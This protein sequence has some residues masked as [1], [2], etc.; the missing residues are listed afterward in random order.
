MD[1]PDIKNNEGNREDVVTESDAAP[2]IKE[3]VMEDEVLSD[4]VESTNEPFDENVMESVERDENQAADG[5][6][7]MTIK[8]EL[9]TPDGEVVDTAE[10]QN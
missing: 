9:H 1:E 3:E 5:Y 10:G 7:E 4:E 6:E 8:H 2:D